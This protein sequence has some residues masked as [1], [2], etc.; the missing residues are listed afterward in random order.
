M[1]HRLVRI[2]LFVAGLMF[3][4]AG[5]AHAQAWVDVPGSLAV[6]ADYAYSPSDRVFD[7][8]GSNPPEVDQLEV[9]TVTIGAEYVPIEKLGISLSIPLMSVAYKGDPIAG[10]YPR[11]GRYDDGRYHTTLQDMRLMAR[12]QLTGPFLAI[13]PHLA[14]IMPLSDYETVGYAAAGRGL[15]QLAIGSSIGKLFDF[16]LYV[17][18]QLEFLLSEK[19]E[20]GLPAIDEIGQNRLDTNLSIGYFFSDRLEAN[21]A[22][23][24]R[25]ALGG[26]DF[27]EVS[28]DS[29]FFGFHDPLLADE[30]LTGGLGGSF[31]V[32]DTLRVTAIFRYFLTGKNTRDATTLGLGVA[33]DVL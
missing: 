28:E 27:S 9:H 1:S 2:A 13:T 18:G 14:F 17:H 5:A 31:A 12:Y 19:Y 15:K 6:S 23:S 3:A 29:A 24:F 30:Q 21:L 20:V 22:F 25:K 33:W 7:E 11:H 26:I 32:T 4:A 16:R 8:Y 10:G